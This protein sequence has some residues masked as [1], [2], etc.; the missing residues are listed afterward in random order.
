MSPDDPPTTAHDHYALALREIHEVTFELAAHWR[1]QRTARGPMVLAFVAPVAMRKPAHSGEPP[2]GWT[3]CLITKHLLASLNGVWWIPSGI[4][5]H[6]A[7]F[8]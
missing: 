5:D 4:V 1:K 3:K 8:T 6:V 7:R 2:E